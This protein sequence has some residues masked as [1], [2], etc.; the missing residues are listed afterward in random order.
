MG[1]LFLF[2][3]LLFQNNRHLTHSPQITAKHSPQIRVSRLL[4]SR[5]MCRVF[6]SRYFENYKSSS[7][8]DLIPQCPIELWGHLEGKEYQILLAYN[9]FLFYSLYYPWD[10]GTH[11]NYS[12]SSSHLE[13]SKVSKS[14]PK[15][16]FSMLLTSEELLQSY[17]EWIVIIIAQMLK[18]TI[19]IKT[20]SF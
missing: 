19:S 20:I 1:T 7:C 12:L 5:I 14:A 10:P 6:S 4:R 11:W 13:C 18:V 8:Y 9:S 3:G 2:L 15:A 17:Q 16:P